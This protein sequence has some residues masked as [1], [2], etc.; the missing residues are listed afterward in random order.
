MQPPPVEDFVVYVRYKL[1]DSI[2]A[3]GEFIYTHTHALTLTLTLVAI[4][5]HLKTLLLLLRAT[6]KP[7]G[8]SVATIAIT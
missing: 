7:M 1:L 6:R 3:P 5:L 8:M 2:G 4:A